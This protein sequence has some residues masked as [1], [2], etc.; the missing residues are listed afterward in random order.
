MLVIP[1]DPTGWKALLADP[2]KHW[3][4][5]R[6]AWELAH[7][8]TSAG[9]GFPPEVAAAFA[10]EPALADLQPQIVIA[11]YQVALVGRGPRRRVPRRL[12]PTRSCL[13]MGGTPGS[14][15]LL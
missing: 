7:S 11:E 8:W 10:S 1:P 14:R 9:D 6:S 13:R 15:R 3:K 5:G 12:R 2:N 4:R